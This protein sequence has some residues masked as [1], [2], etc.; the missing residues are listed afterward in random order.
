VHISD[1]GTFIMNGGTITADNKASTAGTNV[2][3]GIRRRNSAAGPQAQM[4]SRVEGGAGAGNE[5]I[6]QT[7][8]DVPRHITGRRIPPC[9]L[10]Y[11]EGRGILSCMRLSGFAGQPF[12]LR[13]AGITEM[14]VPYVHS[15]L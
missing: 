11:P 7:V 4:D 15:L 12:W 9:S 14:C 6:G 8:E 13:P 3:G 1:D 10:S 5:A 2:A